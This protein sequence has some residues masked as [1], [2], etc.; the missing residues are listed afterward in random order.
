MPAPSNAAR[1]QQQAQFP[2]QVELDHGRSGPRRVYLVQCCATWLA[3]RF[4]PGTWTA[5]NPPYFTWDRTAMTTTPEQISVYGF[6][7]STDAGAFKAFGMALDAM[8]ERELLELS[9]SFGDK[10]CRVEVS[11]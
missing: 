6:K 2:Y 5:E 11:R 7:Q 8:S 9:K 10:I 3:V 4:P 1:R